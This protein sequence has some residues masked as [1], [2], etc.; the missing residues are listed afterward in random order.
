MDCFFEKPFRE[1][2]NAQQT[3]LV[4]IVP[5]EILDASAVVGHVAVPNFVTRHDL[6]N[7]SW[8]VRSVWTEQDERDVCE[9]TVP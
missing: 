2:K 7:A 1:G 5:S 4:S 3:R 8:T 9:E 6:G